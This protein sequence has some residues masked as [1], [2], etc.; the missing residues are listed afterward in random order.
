MGLTGERTL[1]TKAYEL[2]RGTEAVSAP[3]LVN[4]YCPADYNRD[5]FVD[6]IDYDAFFNDFEGGDPDADFNGDGFVDGIDADLF[7]N[8]FEGG[9]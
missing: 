9:C 2:R 6:G 8:A 1:V 4:V 5:G 7:N 3:V